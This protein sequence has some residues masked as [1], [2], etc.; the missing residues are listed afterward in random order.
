MDPIEKGEISDATSVTQA[1]VNLDEIFGMPDAG[2][3]MLPETEEKKSVFSKN[4]VDVSFID[5]PAG[6]SVATDTPAEKKEVEEAIAELDSRIAQEE[7]AGS[8]G[9]PKIDK[10]GLAE[11]ATKMIE[12]GTLI[13]FDDDKSLDEYTA[14]D[15]REL[16]QVASN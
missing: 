4:T 11:L 10:S 16:E 5:N 9:R 1:D 6:T 12:E 8:K 3:I 15:F 14:K 7:E 13:P 2:N